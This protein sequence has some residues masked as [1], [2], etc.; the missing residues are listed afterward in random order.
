MKSIKQSI[1]IYWAI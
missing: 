1:L